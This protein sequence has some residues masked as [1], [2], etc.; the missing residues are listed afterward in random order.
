MYNKEKV[1][2]KTLSSCIQSFTDNLR[3]AITNKCI[4]TFFKSS[5]KYNDDFALETP[6]GHYIEIQNEIELWTKD[7]MIEFGWYEE[8]SDFC[9]SLALTSAE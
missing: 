8:L 3:M 9:A 1:R 7:T 4:S 5:L 2:G 6:K